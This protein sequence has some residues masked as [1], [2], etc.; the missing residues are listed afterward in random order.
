MFDTLDLDTA[1]AG[2]SS[3]LR[4]FYEKNNNA[5][6]RIAELLQPILAINAENTSVSGRNHSGKTTE[7]KTYAEP[8]Q[9]Y[10]SAASFL[11]VRFSASTLSEVVAQ[12][13]RGMELTVF[14][15][16]YVNGN[17][18]Y[19]VQVYG[20]TGFASANYIAVGE[21]ATAF[22]AE[23]EEEKK[24]EKEMPSGLSV[25]D[26]LP[27]LCSDDQAKLKTIAA[28]I[29]YCLT[30]VY[31]EKN[32]SEDYISTYSVLVYLIELYQQVSDIAFQNQLTDLY[33][34]AEAGMA[35]ANG[36]R[37]RL[38]LL[39]GKSDEDF[40]QDILE[41]NEEYQRAQKEEEE[42]K[43]AAEKAAREAE[44]A[45]IAAEQAAAAAAQAQA[46]EAARIA[47]AQAAAAAEAARQANAQAQAEAQAAAQEAA[48]IAAEAMA[49]AIAIAKQEGVG[50]IGRQMAD[51]AESFVGWLPYVW[52]GA[53]L[54]Y[55]CDCSG[56][57]GQIL[58]H[59]GKLDQG[60]ANAH[61]Y[62]SWDYRSLGYQVANDQVQPGDIVCYDGHVAIYFGNGLIIHEPAEGRKCEYGLIGLGGRAYTVR[63]M[64]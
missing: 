9:G 20:M 52:G 45:R 13:V 28:E 32:A 26:I 22:L 23:L 4:T 47:A 57:L 36:N 39:T 15:E 50:T 1:V 53:S 38:S 18:W 17:L 55:G 42:R 19:K 60:A 40:H 44:A 25:E 34:K 56:F 16:R 64:P 43:A 8:K 5:A 11:N 54:Q 24:E 3:S 14:G 35:A 7:L 12:A 41:A 33:E 2:A 49:Q 51:Y 46:Q 62:C 29:T 37:E 21:D 58:A 63:R 48:R 10:C 27:L 6:E 61:R 30:T 59:F 31:P